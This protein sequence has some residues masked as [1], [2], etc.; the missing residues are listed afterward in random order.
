VTRGGNKVPNHDRFTSK[1]SAPQHPL[2]RES[3]ETQSR[4][5]HCVEENSS[6]LCWKTNNSSV[7]RVCSLV[8]TPT[9]LSRLPRL[10]TSTIFIFVEFSGPI[11]KN[12]VRVSVHFFADDKSV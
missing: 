3:G 6:S 12:I 8:T 5:G 10:T 4:W 1:S 7:V 2:C 11:Q 9:E